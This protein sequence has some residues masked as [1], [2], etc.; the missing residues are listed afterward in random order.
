MPC[1]DL[2]G[3]DPE[4]VGCPSSI[5]ALINAFTEIHN[6]VNSGQV[7]IFSSHLDRSFLR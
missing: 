6:C 5:I 1:E 7:P 2:L 3:E 4:R